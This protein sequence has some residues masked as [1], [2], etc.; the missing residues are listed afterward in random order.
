[1]LSLGAGDTGAGR[2]GWH[3][4]RDPAGLPFCV[5]ENSPEQTRHRD[6]G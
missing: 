2:G 6:L 4:L 3:V 1:V 5:T